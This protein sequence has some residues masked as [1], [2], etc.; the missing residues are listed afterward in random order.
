MS[1]AATGALAMVAIGGKSQVLCSK[2]PNNSHGL[3]TPLL[4]FR[5][6]LQRKA[7]L[8]EFGLRYPY[9][10]SQERR[11]EFFWLTCVLQRGVLGSGKATLMS[12][13]SFP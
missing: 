7:G 3:G 1:Q 5:E 11:L 6:E 13:L 10:S 9:I 8:A 4:L 2:Q 12:R